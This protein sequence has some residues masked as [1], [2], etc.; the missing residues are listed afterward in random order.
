M[1]DPTIPPSVLKAAKRG[2]IR[3]TAQSYSTALAGGISAAVIITTIQGGQP[4]WVALAVTAGVA[5]V[6]PL[7]AGS[8]SFLSILAKGVPADYL[9]AE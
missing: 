9:A 8:A 4:D 6:S 1:S 7:L 3:T 5:V 2:F